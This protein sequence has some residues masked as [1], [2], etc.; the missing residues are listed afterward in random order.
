MNLNEANQDIWKQKPSAQ[1]EG[2]N[3]KEAEQIAAKMALKKLY[4]IE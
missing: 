2:K 4:N 1:G 3:I